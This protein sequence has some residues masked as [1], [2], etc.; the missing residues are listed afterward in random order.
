MVWPVATQ[1]DLRKAALGTARRRLPKFLL[2]RKDGL[3]HAPGRTS[4]K[5]DANDFPNRLPSGPR[6]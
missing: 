6:R 4:T 3:P 2:Q 1:S 5:A